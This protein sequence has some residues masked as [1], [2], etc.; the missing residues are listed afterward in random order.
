MNQNLKKPLVSVVI[1]CY[2]GAEYLKQAVE[3]V[4]FQTYTNWELIFWDNQSIDGSAEIVKSFRDSRIIYILSERHTNLGEARKMAVERCSGDF[5]AFLDCDDYWRKNKLELQINSFH[6]KKVVLSYGG[7]EIID[8]DS[9][10]ICEV[11]PLYNTGYIF[12]H[13]LSYFDINMTT[14]MIRKSVLIDN[15]LNFEGLIYASEEV[16]LFLKLAYLGDVACIREVLATSRVTG[17]SLTNHSIDYWHSDLELTVNQLIEMDASI[18]IRFKDEYSNVIAKLY[19]YKSRF[20]LNNSSFLKSF[21][22]AIRASFLNYKYFI[23][24]FILVSPF[25]NGI[26]HLYENRNYRY[27][28][29]NMMKSLSMRFF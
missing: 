4:I 17:D 11:F 8:F 6:S 9:N 12:P 25:T 14:P 5:I 29:K 24:L 15:G 2:N 16:N 28:L 13:L 1:N 23:Y 26:L 20:Y 10:S 7:V 3:S 19:Y 22:Y 21:L 27:K 18:P